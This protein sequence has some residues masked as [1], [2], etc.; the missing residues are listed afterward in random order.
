M[1]SEL[2]SISKSEP[3]LINH[4]ELMVWHPPLYKFSFHIQAMDFKI[5]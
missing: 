2:L 1:V 4:L 3:S 5:S